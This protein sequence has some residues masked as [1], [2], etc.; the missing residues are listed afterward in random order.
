MKSQLSRQVCSACF[1]L[2]WLAVLC[3]RGR[4]Q[5]TAEPQQ[6]LQWWPDTTINIRLNDQLK[7]VVYLTVRPGRDVSA[8]VTQQYGTGLNWALSKD[9]ST[10]L[11]YRYI[12]SDPS[13]QRHSVEH[14]FHVDVTP[15]FALGHG[16]AMTNRTRAEYRRINGVVSGRFRDRLQVERNISLGE[17]KFTPYVAGETYFDTRAHTLSRTQMWLGSRIPL[18]RHVSLD[19]FYM[20]QWD[21]RSRPG[22]LHV[23][24]T[25]LRFEL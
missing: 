15:R 6:D 25:Y 19:G 22:F 13:E 21:A 16:F 7:Y 24:G 1:F 17:H 2:L 3:V 23:L 5:T 12:K 11:Q 4:A 14:R 18:N 9:L 8:V 10:S 20:H